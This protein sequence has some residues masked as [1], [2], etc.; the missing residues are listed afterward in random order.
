LDAGI[1]SLVALGVGQR[2]V[3]VRGQGYLADDAKQRPQRLVKLHDT[4]RTLAL[5]DDDALDGCAILPLEREAC[6]LTHA[7]PADDTAPGAVLDAAQQQQFDLAASVGFV[8]VQP[9]R[10][11]PRL[12][13]NQ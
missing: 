11:D 10:D 7:S 9:R 4:L 13:E 8:A 1:D 5:F 12:V 6:P 3:D 2:F